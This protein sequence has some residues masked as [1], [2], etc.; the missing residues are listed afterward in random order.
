[1]NIT[2]ITPYVEPV[3]K[4]V[5]VSATPEHAFEVFTS[6]MSRWWLR[7]H[8][9]N[10]TK[11]PIEDVVIEPRV[12]GRWYERGTDGTECNWGKVLVWEPP[13]RLVLAWQIDAR[14]QS[15]ADFSTEVEIQFRPQASGE[16]EVTLEHRQLERYGDSAAG[17]QK[18]LDGGW[19]SLLD[20]F[21]SEVSTANP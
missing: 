10:P 3:F 2:G 13:S 4:S 8:S 17:L 14:F 12:G 19:Q 18:A 15:N 16:T 5:R 11:S 7:T 6:G 1:M 21:A 9:V 20:L